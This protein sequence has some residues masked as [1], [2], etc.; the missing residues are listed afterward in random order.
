MPKAPHYSTEEIHIMVSQMNRKRGTVMATICEPPYPPCI[1]SN[2][3]SYLNLD[4]TQNQKKVALYAKKKLPVFFDPKIFAFSQQPVCLDGYPPVKLLFFSGRKTTIVGGLSE[5]HNR[6]VAWAITRYLRRKFRINIS[7]L[8][9]ST[10]NIVSN[11]DMPFKINLE[12]IAEKYDGRAKYEPMLI[13][14]CRVTSRHGG[15][16]V[17]LVFSTGSI[18]LIGCK[19]MDQVRLLYIESC[20]VATENKVTADEQ[21]PRVVSEKYKQK[22]KLLNPDTVETTNIDI[23]NSMV[24]KRRKILKSKKS[25]AVK[26]V[27]LEHFD[28]TYQMDRSATYKNPVSEITAIE[29]PFCPPAT[30]SYLLA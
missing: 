10:K 17:Y 19:T 2:V 3:V 4:M 8:D 12:K 30:S 18:L 20:E 13:D 24:V 29:H 1:V 27:V 5:D 23:E 7:I 6:L 16:M 21:V 25:D 11:V 26:R 22:R 9:F 28:N 15:S 14:C